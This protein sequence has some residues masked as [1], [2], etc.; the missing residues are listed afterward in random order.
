MKVGK[1][2]A[3]AQLIEIFLTY[4]ILSKEEFI[5]RFELTEDQF[6]RYMADAKKYFALFHNDSEIVYAKGEGVYRLQPIRKR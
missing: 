3:F 1:A 4:R 5:E 2:L 6:H